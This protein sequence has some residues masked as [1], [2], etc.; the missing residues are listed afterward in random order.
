[1]FS[2]LGMLPHLR[3]DMASKGYWV[4]PL[5]HMGTVLVVTGILAFVF[6]NQLFTGTNCNKDSSY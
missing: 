5:K 2:D 6:Y 3:K 4:S 1:M